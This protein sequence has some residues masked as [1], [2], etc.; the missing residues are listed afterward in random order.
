MGGNRGRKIKKK[1]WEKRRTSEE[2]ETE[3]DT[4]EITC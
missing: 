2:R 4:G 3:E 1:I